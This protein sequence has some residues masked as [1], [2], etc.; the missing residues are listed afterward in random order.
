MF[1]SVSNRCVS[2]VTS[3]S[4]TAP[5]SPVFIS[6]RKNMINDTSD[7]TERVQGGYKDEPP[8]ALN[9]QNVANIETKKVRLM[10]THYL[11]F[12]YPS[13]YVIIF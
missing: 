7:I 3:A 11:P 6:Q 10:G 8:Q 4:P 9:S 2:P 5:E 12:I 13:F 1:V